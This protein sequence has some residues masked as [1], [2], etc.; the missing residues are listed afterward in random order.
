M[1]PPVKQEIAKEGIFPYS[2]VFAQSYDGSA[3]FNRIIRRKPAPK[4]TLDSVY[5]DDTPVATLALHWLITTILVIAPILALQPKPY[6][7]GP[8]YAYLTIAFVYNIDLTCF[9]FISLGLLCLRFTPSVRWAQK[10]EFKH[11]WV[12]ITAA[13]IVLIV[14]AFPLIFIWVPDPAFPKATHTN[15]LVS[16]FAGQTFA[17]CLL[18]LAAF[19]WVVFRAYIRIRSGREGTT[20]HIKRKPIFRQD[21]GGVWTQIC[22][23]VTM[24]WK[25][26]VGLRLEDIEESKDG[27]G[28]TTVGESVA[29]SGAR[30]RPRFGGSE[31]RES[32]F[33]EEVYEVGQEYGIKRKPIATELPT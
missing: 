27:L 30:R 17:I 5:S 29:D 15:N 32:S 10:S 6:S 4:A 31:G 18:A 26:E 3:L 12:S 20:L 23:I 9:V 7:S 16:W 13:F 24:E 8:A 1:F 19:Y 33:R 11:P 14:C 25:R 22:E 21:S 2:I 28:S